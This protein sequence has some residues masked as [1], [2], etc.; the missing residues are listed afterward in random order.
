MDTQVDYANLVNGQASGSVAN[1]LLASNMDT[2]CLRPYIGTDGRSYIDRAYNGEVKAIPTT[3]ANATLL[4]REWIELDKAV[5]RVALPMLR[6]V[7]DLRGRG[8]TYLMQNGMATTVLQ[9]QNASDISEASI[10]MDG[11][12]DSKGDRPVFNSTFLPLPI[13]HK[14][15][16]FPMRDILVSRKGSMPLDLTMAEMA[17]RKVAEG[18]EQLLLGTN[19]NNYSY[20]GGTVYGYTN[21]PGRIT[22]TLSSP[23]L[24]AWIARNTILDILDMRATLAAHFRY[25]PYVLYVS[26]AWDRYMD[27]D[28]SMYKGTDTLRE[29][30]EKIDGIDGVVTVDYLKGYDMVLVQLSNDVVREVVGADITT[31]QWES[32]GGMQQN[33]KVMAILVPQLRGDFN[34][35]SGIVHGS[36]AGQTFSP[37]GVLYV[38]TTNP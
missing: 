1:A 14:D 3:N 19:P 17:A 2:R 38:N 13:I 18:A 23:L 26:R 10:S 36:V 6:A 25:G 9:S 22:K 37:T 33:F 31:I 11:L 35:N 21:Y 27:D 28:H 12:A 24:S 16:S 7:S 30:I 20:G 32:H 5:S 15:F 34:A 4:V 8:L 29:R